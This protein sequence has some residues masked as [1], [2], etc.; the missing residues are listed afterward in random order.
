LFRHCLTG[1][2]SLFFPTDV[3]DGNPK[4]SVALAFCEG[5]AAANIGMINTT[6]VPVAIPT[7]KA[8]SLVIFNILNYLI[9]IDINHFRNY[10]YIV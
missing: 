1:W 9:F 3:E 6:M 4:R 8:P 2:I 5:N 10:Y 7:A